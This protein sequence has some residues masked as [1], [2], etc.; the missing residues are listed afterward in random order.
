MKKLSISLLILCSILINIGCTTSS[1]LKDS[2]IID[3][4][5]SS[6]IENE[7]SVQTNEMGTSEVKASNVTKATNT[8]KI[9]I[10]LMAKDIKEEKNVKYLEVN[11]EGTLQDKTELIVNAISKECFNNLPMKVTVDRKDIAKVELIEPENVQNSRV[12]WKDD[13]LNEYIKED[14]LSIILKNILQEEYKGKWIEKVQL[15]YEGE[16]ISLN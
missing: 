5:S 14:T 11:E 9:P 8:I 2:N 10:T 15:Y 12:S 6:I 4:N 7:E 1:K 13:Y 3:L 16:L